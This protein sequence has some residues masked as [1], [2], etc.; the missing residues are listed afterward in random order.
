MAAPDA[1]ALYNQVARIRFPNGVEL[2]L[3]FNSSQPEGTLLPI[4]IL[5]GIP[6]RADDPTKTKIELVL[7]IKQSDLD[8]EAMATGR[9]KRG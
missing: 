5:K 1:S 6:M 9:F 2:P 7:E 3:I 8:I 4:Q